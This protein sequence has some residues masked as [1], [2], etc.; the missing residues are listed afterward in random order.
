MASW[1]VGMQTGEPSEAGGGNGA[2]DL[3]ETG[4]EQTETLLGQ[5]ALEPL[6]Q[7]EAHILWTTAVASFIIFVT[8][9]ML[10]IRSNASKSARG[11]R[12]GAEKDF[13]QPAGEGAEIS[14]DDDE[15]PSKR[16]KGA[17]SANPLR[18]DDRKKDAAALS[19]PVNEEEPLIGARLATPAKTVREGGGISAFFGRNKK[20]DEDIQ[21]PLSELADANPFANA[22]SKESDGSD[23]EGGA[24]FSPRAEPSLQ[25]GDDEAAAARRQ[26]EEEFRRI[27]QERRAAADREADF[28]RRKHLAAIEQQRRALEEQQQELD[29]QKSALD[30]HIEELRRDLADELDARFSALGQGIDE[31]LA[32]VGRSSLGGAEEEIAAALRELDER[33]SLLSQRISSRSM[34]EH[35]ESIAALVTQRISEQRD[36]LDAAIASM[37]ERIDALA[38]KTENLAA[39]TSDP[40]KVKAPGDW[41]VAAS[42]SIQLSDIVRNALPPDAYEM[43][44]A[45]PD[46]RR[47]DCLL[48]LPHPP[49]P[50]AIDAQFPLE[51]FHRLHSSTDEMRAENEFRRTALRHIADVAERLIVPGKT[52]NSAMMFLPSENFHAELHARFPDVIQDSYRAQVWIVSPTSLMA[53]LST[54]RAALR[55]IG[56]PDKTD[57]RGSGADQVFAELASLRDRLES[58]ESRLSADPNDVGLAVVRKAAAD[59][60]DREGDDATGGNA[61]DQGS[62]EA[63]PSRR[64]ERKD[65]NKGD[66]WEEDSG[67]PATPFPLR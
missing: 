34:D 41:R 24:S 1:G 18:A 54:M 51:A 55:D 16:G 43:R 8:I 15:A 63:Q 3:S 61:G 19:P 49:G 57:A 38:N 44:A 67:K 52:A 23:G 35:I 45:L 53:T 36:V 50:M 65:S 13:F 21:R 14:F 66:L 64:A 42:P 9:I 10:I 48:R 37:S 31:R 32:H 2:P 4:Q 56:A 6:F 58:L 11:A 22:G 47:A 5:P 46:N 26:V 29:L 62:A 59:D 33:L 27:E 40:E 7:G 20:R 12:A 60:A 39:R 17:K 28:E 30:R 25:Y